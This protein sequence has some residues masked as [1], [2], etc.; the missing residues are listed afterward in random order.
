MNRAKCRNCGDLLHS[1]HRRDFVTCKCFTNTED[2]TGIFIDGGDEY[3]RGGG[4]LENIIRIDDEGNEIDQKR[5]IPFTSQQIDEMNARQDAYL[6]GKITSQ[7]LWQN[8][9]TDGGQ[10]E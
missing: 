4:Q 6:S 7:D 9:E 8:P 1:K 3:L 5:R 10:I 2:C